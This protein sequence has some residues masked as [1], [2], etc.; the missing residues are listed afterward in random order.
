ML[1]RRKGLINLFNINEQSI[2]YVVCPYYNK[3][4][5]TEL[6]HQLVYAI[7]QYGG[8]AIITYYGGENDPKKVN[9]AFQDY[10]SS[11]IDIKDVIDSPENVIVLPEIRPDLSDGLKYIQKSV[12]WMSVDN[13]LKR[14]GVFGSLRY[15]GI[16]KTF[17]LLVK[18]KIKIGG[19]KIDNNIIHLYQSEYAHQ[20]LHKKGIKETHR[21]SDYLNESYFLQ[22]PFNEKRKDIVLYN[23]KK[24][25]NFT[26]KIMK[27]A[28]D[29]TFLPIQ[30]MSTEQVK[31]LLLH[32]KVYIDFG[33]HPGK[34]RFPREAAISGCC[35]I[36]GKRGSA[37]YYEDIPILDAYKFK[38]VVANVPEIVEVLRSCLCKYD[39][40]IIDFKEYQNF[41]KSEKKLFEGD[42][43]ELFI[44]DR[45]IDRVN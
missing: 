21:L 44:R 4:G 27:Q 26:Q 10:V 18:G 14:N 9:P 3:T 36:T 37:G 22:E 20:F 11:F 24:G 2:I 6:V 23:P 31:E 15:L 17:K 38:D 12:W 43:K 28:P 32:S 8:R 7:N 33:N 34:D 42:V 5:G 29:L 1:S 41:I 39:E 25:I 13:Y 19:Y 45:S 40:H 16:W 30:N 35:V